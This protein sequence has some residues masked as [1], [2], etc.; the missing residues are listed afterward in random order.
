M[1][2]EGL[3]VDRD[4]LWLLGSHS[5]ARKQVKGNAP[6]A[7]AQK[8][9]ATVEVSQRRRVLARLSTK[10]LLDPGKTT[11]APAAARR[12]SRNAPPR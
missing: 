11:S 5:S 1:D 9:L 7:E 2:I 12:I 8:S 10:T 3:D 6:P 4:T